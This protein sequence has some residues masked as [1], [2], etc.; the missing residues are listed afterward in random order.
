MAAMADPALWK[1]DVVAVPVLAIYAGTSRLPDVKAMQ[2]TLPQFEAT[3]VAGTGHFVMME[4]PE[5]FNRLLSAFLEKA[6]F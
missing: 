1:E 2:K 5:E 6:K 4:K 3:Q